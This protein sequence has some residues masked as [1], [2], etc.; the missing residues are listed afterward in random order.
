M[1]FGSK[2]SEFT[3]LMSQNCENYF[4]LLTHSY[5]FSF[6]TFSL[7][8]RRVI[9]KKKKKKNCYLVNKTEK[10]FPSCFPLETHLLPVP[11]SC[12]PPFI[13]VFIEK[14]SY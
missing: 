5:F 11:T 13:H 8:K 1:P 2:G 14:D 6:L 10:N 9:K 4:W 7:L 12:L 3:V